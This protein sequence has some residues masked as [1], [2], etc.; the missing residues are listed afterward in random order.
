M[1]NN[2]KFQGITELESS[3]GLPRGIDT[4]LYKQLISRTPDY[5]D[6]NLVQYDMPYGEKLW[7]LFESFQPGK[8]TPTFSKDKLRTNRI[9]GNLEDTAGY[10]PGEGGAPDTLFHQRPSIPLGLLGYGLGNKPLDSSSY[11]LK[12][13]FTPEIFKK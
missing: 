3:Y 12:R 9:F 6:E 2:D 4:D 1:A 11:S 13:M 5:E 8:G 7:E 10:I